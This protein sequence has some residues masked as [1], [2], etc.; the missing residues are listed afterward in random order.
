MIKVYCKKFQWGLNFVMM[1]IFDII[2]WCE[3]MRALL[4]VGSWRL[5]KWAHTFHWVHWF[6]E[7]VHLKDLGNYY[8]RM[9]V[10][11]SADDVKKWYHN[12]IQLP[13][14]HLTINFDRFK[15]IF[16]TLKKKKLLFSIFFLKLCYK[17][18]YLFNS[19]WSCFSS[20]LR[21]G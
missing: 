17:L 2:S 10:L 19:L 14:K 20:K 8:E 3:N 6:S 13:L 21:G 7:S 15:R 16:L 4:V 9:L 18:S 12:K 5:G 1:P 11:R